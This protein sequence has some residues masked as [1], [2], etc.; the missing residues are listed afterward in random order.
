MRRYL[1]LAI[2]ATAVTTAYAGE[3]AHG[4]FNFQ[5]QI[6]VSEFKENGDGCLTIM[7]DSLRETETI[8]LI[9]LQEPQTL[10]QANI[11]NKLSQ[12]CSRNTEV[13]IGAFFYS[14]RN[15]KKKAELIGPAIAI[16]GFG[17]NFKVAGGKVRTDLNNDGRLESFRVCTSNEG[18]HLTI[19]AGEPLK[20]KRLWHEYYYLGYD[21][22][23]NCTEKDYEQ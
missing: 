1:L 12:S 6:G 17:G 5:R 13:P 23:P 8:N 7:N 19:W 2:F 10:I 4:V 22:E 15:G 18:F 11:V 16:A 20:N 3:T 9:S 14:F 21:V